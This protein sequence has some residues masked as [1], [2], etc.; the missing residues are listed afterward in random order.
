MYASLLS[1]QHSWGNEEGKYFCIWNV[2]TLCV[3]WI[4][5]K[6]CVDTIKN[7]LQSWRSSYN[8]LFVA[9]NFQLF[10]E[11]HF[12]DGKSALCWKML[13]PRSLP[14]DKQGPNV[15]GNRSLSTSGKP[16][17]SLLYRLLA[18]A[19]PFALNTHEKEEF[20]EIFSMW[21]PSDSLFS[22]HLHEIIV[23]AH[24]REESQ[25]FRG[26]LK[27][28]FLGTDFTE[29]GRASPLMTQTL[30][31]KHSYPTLIDNDH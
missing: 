22:S 31:S 28:C 18:F 6:S 4:F 14:S 29:Y 3:P 15:W 8:V 30:N 21:V 5:G 16:T 11:S 1:P 12:G 9:S 10:P 7:S 20:Q 25:S 2:K 13:F 24:A 19:S 23:Q 26:A 17:W 27:G